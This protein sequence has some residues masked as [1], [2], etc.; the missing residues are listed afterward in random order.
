LV[1]ELKSHR[2]ATFRF[3]SG[4]QEM[5]S[6]PLRVPMAQKLRRTSPSVTMLGMK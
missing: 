5:I 1:D 2:R 6:L 4:C 3:Q